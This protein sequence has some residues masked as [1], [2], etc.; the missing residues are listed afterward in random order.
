MTLARVA[1]KKEK[2]TGLNSLRTPPGR[3][4][5]GASRGTKKN[6]QTNLRKINIKSG[7]P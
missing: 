7:F 3:W 6:A 2:G 1:E 4:G 5:A